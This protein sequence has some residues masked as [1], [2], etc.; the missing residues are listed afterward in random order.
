MGLSAG[1]VLPVQRLEPLVG[2]MGVDLGGGE[3]RMAQ[4]HLYHPQIGAVVEQMG[5][6]GVAQGMGG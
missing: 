4:Q 2:H 6:K 3:I 5:G 1:V